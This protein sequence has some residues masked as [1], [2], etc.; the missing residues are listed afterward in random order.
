MGENKWND[1]EKNNEKRTLQHTTIFS[2]Y[3]VMSEDSPNASELL[4]TMAVK[5]KG[6]W[7][8]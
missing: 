6:T 1:N 7:R 5:E 4:R 3:V 8:I 2:R